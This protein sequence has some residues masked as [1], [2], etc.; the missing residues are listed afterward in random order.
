MSEV[1]A[2]R[3]NAARLLDEAAK[4]AQASSDAAPTPLAAGMSNVVAAMFRGL[5][6]DIRSGKRAEAQETT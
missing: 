6:T 4:K 3:E 1:E 2:E 5:A